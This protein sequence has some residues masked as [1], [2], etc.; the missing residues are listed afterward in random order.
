MEDNIRCIPMVVRFKLDACGIKLKLAQWSRFSPEE[1]NQLTDRPCAGIWE[2]RNY[3]AYLESLIL[4]RTG[5][6][7][8]MIDVEDAP[9][10][11][12]DSLILPELQDQ[13][14]KIG[15]AIGVQQWRSLTKLQR[16]A[17]IKLC[18]PGHENRN[19]PIAMKEFGL[20][21]NIS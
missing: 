11:A 20:C 15:A 10:W 12:D 5:Q 17:L 21:V 9:A 8:T 2:I 18:R 7:A 6:A 1:R 14:Q 16:F 13:A 19:F 4:L 3:Q